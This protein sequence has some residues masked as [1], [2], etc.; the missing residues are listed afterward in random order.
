MKIADL[1]SKQTE[2][3][4][5]TLQ[6]FE[7]HRQLLIK[8]G[9][10]LLEDRAAILELSEALAELAGHNIHTVLVHGGGPQLSAAT[11]G[12][13][14]RF[15]EGKRYTDKTTLTL[16]ERIFAMLTKDLVRVISDDGVRTT[17]LPAADLFG[18]KRDATL[19]LV[20]TEITSVETTKIVQ[21][22][23]QHSVLVIHSLAHDEATNETLNVNSDTIF[24]ALATTLQ[25]HRMTS[26]T[27]TGGV[28]K[29]IKNSS[30]QELI[31]G[32]DVRDVEALIGEGIVSGGMALKLREL[33]AIL[34]QLEVGS[35]ISIARPAELLLELLTDQGSGTYV[36]KGPKIITTND[37][38]DVYPDLALLIKEVFGKSLPAGYDKRA[39]EKI[40]F[41][42]DRL[43]FGMVTTL[44]NGTPYL[45]KLAV[46]PQLQGRGIGESLW[47][48]IAADFPVIVWRSHVTNR[49]ATWYHRHADIMKRQGEWILFGHGI[50]F[51][52]FESL[53]QELI[54]IPAMR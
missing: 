21:A 41:T 34:S 27:P 15:V 25:P 3:Y 32:I 12:T 17:S 4:I 38:A 28:L 52:A 36:S 11:S 5:A 23:Q 43:A 33:A 9:G 37:V 46:S 40:Y 49:Y 31:T 2:R 35:A 30:A 26:L 39:V 51:P 10:G 14:P 19:G 45:D 54:S 6:S 16:A 48:R 13:N 44:S 42:A 1:P 29:P 50:D 20:G 47:Y 24:R 18:A 53:A 22:M 8:V 7:P